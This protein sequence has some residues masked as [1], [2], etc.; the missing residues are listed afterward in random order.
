MP[1]VV[2]GTANPADYVVRADLALCAAG[3]TLGELAYLGCP[4][5]AFAIVPDQEATAR[6]QA[7]AGLIA[8]GGRLTTL[9]DEPLR[10]QIAAFLGDEALRA[11]LRAAA[12][13]SADGYG[14]A[15]VVAALV[16]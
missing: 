6:A 12:L 10:A 3:G 15:R 2:H 7:D 4:A 8:G 1:I 14:A 11:D 13:A 16:A 9:G 5:L